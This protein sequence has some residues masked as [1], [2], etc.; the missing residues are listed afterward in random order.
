MDAGRAR[1]FMAGHARLLDRRRFEGEPEPILAALEAYRNADGGYGWGLEP[2]LRARESQPAGALHAFEAMADAAPLTTPRARALCDWLGAVALEG[3]ALPFA[4]PI[5]DATGVAPFWAGADPA[6]PSLQITAY[7]AGAAW[8]VAAFDDAVR[9]HRWLRD[10]SAWIVRTVEGLDEAPFAIAIVAAL[11][12]ADAC[13]DAAHLVEALARF[14]PD[15]GLIPVPGGLPDEK[16]KPVDV[17]PWPGA[18][19]RALLAPDV[20]AADLRR[21]DAEQAGDGGW[22]VDFASF[23][24]AAALEWRGYATVRAVQVLRRNAGG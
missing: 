6:V 18:P 11:G 23:S 16:L 8:R 1:S 12:F 4:L 3:G 10:V 13:P 19:S 7:V 17:S 14:V 9:E 15:D 20:V 24:P 2:D 22:H 21:L 5:A